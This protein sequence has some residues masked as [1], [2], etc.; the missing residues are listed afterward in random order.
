MGIPFKKIG[1]G[2]HIMLKEER[3][4]WRSCD[5]CGTA[6]FD[7]DQAYATTMGSISEDL[8]GFAADNNEPWL[9]VAC[10]KCGK[11]IS[12]ALCEMIISIRNQKHYWRLS[13]G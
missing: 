8:E 13:D 6:M 10:K 11:K 5:I 3:I 1:A 2:V 9:T 7:G 12:D 4:I